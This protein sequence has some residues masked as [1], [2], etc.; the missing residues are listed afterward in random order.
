L[1]INVGPQ[2]SESKN[3]E[4]YVSKMKMLHQQYSKKHKKHFL[5]V[6]YFLFMELW[7]AS[8]QKKNKG[9]PE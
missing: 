1:I 9:P 3:S 2:N 7:M 8:S 5:L 4:N 6:A